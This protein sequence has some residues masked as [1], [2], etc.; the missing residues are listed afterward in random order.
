MAANSVCV[1]GERVVIKHCYA[2]RRV[3]PLDLYVRRAAPVAA[4]AAIIDYGR[5]IKELAVTN[6]FPGDLLLKN[7]GVT[8]QGR[9][10]FYDYDEVRLLTE[11]RFYRLPEPVDVA[12]ETAGEP[13]Y[14]VA[15]ED[16][17]PEEFVHFLGLPTEL[18]EVFYQYHGDLLTV[19]Y[20]LSVQRRLN[21]GELFHVPPYSEANRLPGRCEAELPRTDF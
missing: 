4:R 7:F 2:E 19:E 3:V 14:G 8:R 18:R 21:Q 6:L 16:V 12:W 15:E 9:V 20:W 10:V 5:A 13:W 11:C 1:E 17:F